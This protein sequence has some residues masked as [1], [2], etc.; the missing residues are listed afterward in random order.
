MSFNLSDYFKKF[1]GLVSQEKIVKERCVEAVKI[2]IGHDIQTKNL[3]VDGATIFLT[4]HPT[5]KHH[6]LQSSSEI[7]QHINNNPFGFRITTIR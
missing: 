1:T 2:F 4:T 3:R 6:I 7:T 5:I